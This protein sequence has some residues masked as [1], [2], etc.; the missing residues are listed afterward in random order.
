MRR[1]LNRQRALLKRESNFT[2]QSKDPKKKLRL[3][4]KGVLKLANLYFL[5]FLYTDSYKE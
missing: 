2:N 4:D 5:Y 1:F 3:F